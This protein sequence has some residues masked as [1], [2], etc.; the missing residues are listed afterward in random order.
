[1]TGK[2]MLS[3]NV[4]S[5]IACLLV[6]C[7]LILSSCQEQAITEREI[8]PEVKEK[9]GGIKA[10][11]LNE[12]ATNVRYNARLQMLEFEDEKHLQ[13]IQASLEEQVMRY[14]EE[15]RGEKE[16][17]ELPDPL[18]PIYKEF[19]A[20]VGFENSLLESHLNK[21][22]EELRSGKHP[23]EIAHAQVDLQS[24]MVLMTDKG[25]L[26]LGD[27][28]YIN[29]REEFEIWIKDGNPETLAQIREGVHYSQ[30]DNV[31]VSGPKTGLGGPRSGVCDAD[32]KITNID[33][34]NK[35]VSVNYTGSSTGANY[36]FYWNWGDNTPNSQGRVQNPHTYAYDNTYNITLTVENTVDNCV[37]TK[38][39][40]V[41][42]NSPVCVAIFTADEGVG[43]AGLV[44]LN[45]NP[46]NLAALAS[47]DPIVQ[48]EWNIN[49]QT[50]TGTNPVTNWT[51]PCNGTYI[52]SLT[53]TTQSGCTN[54]S[55]IAGSVKVTSYG[56]CG[57]IVYMPWTKVTDAYNGNKFFNVRARAMNSIWG[58]KVIAV[59]EHFE[60][61]FLGIYWWKK[62]DMRAALSGEII[63]KSA[64]N[65]TCG[66]ISRDITNNG[67]VMHRSGLYTD[68]I[69]GAD[70]GTEQFN[71]WEAK[72]Y[73]EQNS[74]P[75]KTLKPLVN[76]CNW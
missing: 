34:A 44:I 57:N 7:S 25:E 33:H 45:A 8:S 3:K 10:M 6:S 55:L 58:K 48:Y 20:S 75:F 59:M 65:C 22:S 43:Q 62:R 66:N 32:F 52:V 21:V 56:C 2:G 13:E 47:N 35:S 50:I 63:L 18:H 40:P 46:S 76:A 36:K 71:E 14:D 73:S 5:I 60:K 26:K 54:T 42:I 12:L 49:G 69:V 9:I 74:V 72:F 41:D 16:E 61:G 38:T 68:Y 64:N 70:Y 23:G 4:L 17:E 31:D 37:D 11:S 29:P 67:T 30:F 51:A 28:I 24:Q 39:I 27:K 53:I 15:H 1:M 19:L